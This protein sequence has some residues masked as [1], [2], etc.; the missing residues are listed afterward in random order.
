[1]NKDIPN[2]EEGGRESGGKEGKEKEKEK[3]YMQNL[4]KTK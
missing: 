2:Q 1:M 3:E 4:V